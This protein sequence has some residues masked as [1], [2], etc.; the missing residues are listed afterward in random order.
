MREYYSY[1]RNARRVVHRVIKEGDVLIEVIDSRDPEMFRNEKVEKL[2]SRMKKPMIIVLN[3]VDLIPRKVALEWKESLGMEYPTVLFSAKFRKGVSELKRT[4]IESS[5]RIPV[6]VGILGY[7][8]T[9]KSSIINILKGKRSARTSPIPGFTK[10]YQ[11]YKV[12]PR[13]KVI[14]TPGV[15]YREDIGTLYCLGA[16]RAENI[17]NPPMAAIKLMEY[18]K[19]RDPNILVKTY[20]ID[21]EDPLEFLEELAIR[22]GRVMRGGVPD[23]DEASRIVIRDWQ[24]GKIVV[25]SRPKKVKSYDYDPPSNA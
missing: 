25:W 16:I 2:I 6:K 5:K 19:S 10:H 24:K 1:L 20:G 8:N 4:I 21:C 15:F 13:I 22:R 18:L 12:D 3:K 14:D 11:I 9:G 17:K 7:P 23:I